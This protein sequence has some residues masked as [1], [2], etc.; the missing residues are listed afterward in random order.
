MPIAN[1][2]KEKELVISLFGNNKD[3]LTL[4]WGTHPSSDP[5]QFGIITQKGI[6]KRTAAKKLVKSLN[7]DFSEVLGVGD[8][9]TDW[10]FIE[11]CGYAGAM[12]NA[13]GDLKRNVLK[14]KNS[15]IGGGVNENGLLD[16]FR[17]F[18]PIHY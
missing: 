8:T 7:L 5:Y 14:K 11:L 13:T 10:D 6:S 2:P 16:I 1:G 12:G 15:V 3:Q 18:E 17:H 4:Q 9:I